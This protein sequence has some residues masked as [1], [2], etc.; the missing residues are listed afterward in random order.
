MVNSRNKEAIL[1]EYLTNGGYPD[2]SGKFIREYLKQV[3][4][5][6][7]YRDLLEDYVIRQPSVLEDIELEEF[8]REVLNVPLVIGNSEIKKNIMQNGY[9]LNFVSLFDF[10]YS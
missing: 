7:I 4:D 6:T 9:E 10:L 2:I 3:V 1:N 8:S 5:S